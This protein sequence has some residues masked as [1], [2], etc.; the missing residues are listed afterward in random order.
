MIVHEVA[1][2]TDQIHILKQEVKD[3]H[4]ML[5]VEQVLRRKATASEATLKRKLKKL[6]NHDQ[7][8]NMCRISPSSYKW[9]SETY[10][11]ALKL[12]FACGIAGYDELLEQGH[13]LSSLRSLRCKMEEVSMEPEILDETFIFLKLK[14]AA[15]TDKE[16]DCC[17]TLDEMSIKAG[18]QYDKSSSSFRGDV[19]LPGHKGS[20]THALVFMLAGIT[21]RWKQT[22][23]YHFTGNSTVGSKLKEIVL[24][25]IR[26]AHDIGLHVSTVTSDMGSANRA[27][28]KA[29]GIVCPKLSVTVN[30]IPHPLV[31]GRML[32]FMFDVPHLTKKERQSS[33]SKWP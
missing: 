31:P 26:K 11:K 7:L 30:K 33:P 21:T 29:I 15:L 3:L 20:A 16:R 6:F 9:N 25:I 32:Y 5:R 28:H 4:R 18:Y 12:R 27:L 17:L 2:P 23:C 22:V 8:N 14:V 10:K 13:P 24:E 19:T 1:A